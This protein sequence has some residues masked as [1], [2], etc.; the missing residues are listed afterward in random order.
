MQ[1]NHASKI[2]N[3]PAKVQRIRGLLATHKAH[4]LKAAKTA[5]NASR[6]QPHGRLE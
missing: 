5:A 6:S 3:S 2:R 1:T 4:M